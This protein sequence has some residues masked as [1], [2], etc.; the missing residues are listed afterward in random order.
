MDQDGM[1][2]PLPIMLGKVPDEPQGDFL[3]P[4]MKNFIKGS[5]WQPRHKKIVMNKNKGLSSIAFNRSICHIVCCTFILLPG[6]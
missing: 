1:V 2:K 5:R 6:Q 4:T 3:T